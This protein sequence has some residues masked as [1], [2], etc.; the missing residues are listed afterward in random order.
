MKMNG[1]VEYEG[2]LIFTT[3]FDADKR[4]LESRSP[5]YLIQIW[6]S[7]VKLKCDLVLFLICFSASNSLISSYS[8]K[9][10]KEAVNLIL[11]QN[12]Q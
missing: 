7:S 9:I 2:E 12:H 5:L 6:S 3:H 11:R 4:L 1:Y 8:P 10:A